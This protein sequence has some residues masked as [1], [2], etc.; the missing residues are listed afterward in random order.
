M[1]L[2]LSGR[3]GPDGTHGRFRGR[4]W[5]IIRAGTLIVVDGEGRDI[6]PGRGP[7]GTA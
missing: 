6:I 5:M 3:P 4:S 2:T 1:I 7:G